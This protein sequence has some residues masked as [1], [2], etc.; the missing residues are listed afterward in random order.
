MAFLTPAVTARHEELINGSTFVAFVAPIDSVAAAA[1]LLER[2][3]AEHPD[4]SHHCWAYKFDEVMRFSDDGE[5]AG[6]AGRPMLEVLLKRDLEHCATVV[7]RYFGG[8]KLGIG[9]LVR[10]YG[11]G[12]AKALDLAGVREVVDTDSL[13]IRADFADTDTVLRALANLSDEVATSFDER[14]LVAVIE[15]PSSE[16]L[17]VERLLADITRGAATVK[18]IAT[19]ND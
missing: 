5:P 6:S 15:V 1:A 13:E 3:K 8:K 4:A 18:I 9:G 11:G 12:V 14:G 7:V 17:A 2:V 19:V 10:A 16:R